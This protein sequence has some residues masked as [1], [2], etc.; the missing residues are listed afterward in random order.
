MVLGQKG[1]ILDAKWPAAG[2]TDAGLM[3]KMDFLGAFSNQMRSRL[4]KA[5]VIAKKAQAKNK[6]LAKLSP[7][8]HCT[9]LVA[10]KY[11][12]WQQ[13][14]L[15][16]LSGVV[17]ETGQLPGNRELVKVLAP[18]GFSKKEM[19]D[20]MAFAAVSKKAYESVGRQALNTTSEFDEIA[21]LNK[22]LDFITRCVRAGVFGSARLPLLDFRFL[23][24][25]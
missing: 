6:D 17:K 16:S 19:K 15:E 25:A 23:D 8:D 12:D 13:K 20:A 10:D 9:I 18:M 4:V 7:P 24:S 21:L 1:L 11:P 2:K 14:I 3:R 22:H 5:Q